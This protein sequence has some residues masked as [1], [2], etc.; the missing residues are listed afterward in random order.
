MP[1]EVV[2]PAGYKCMWIV[3]L[4]WRVREIFVFCVEAVI[5]GFVANTVVTHHSCTLKNGVW[6]KKSHHDVV[7]NEGQ[8]KKKKLQ[9]Y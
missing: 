9:S 3:L 8:M 7:T 1:K 2:V 5:D 6:K 4:L